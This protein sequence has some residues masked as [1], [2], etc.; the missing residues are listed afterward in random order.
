MAET[1]PDRLVYV[2]R[3]NNVL[4]LSQGEFVAVSKLEAIYTSSPL[5][6]Q[7]YVYG[8][9]ERAYLLGVIVPSYGA[10]AAHPDPTGF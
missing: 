7:I 2:D 10:L 5:V 6:R 9:S 3:R 8:N 1:G 4:T